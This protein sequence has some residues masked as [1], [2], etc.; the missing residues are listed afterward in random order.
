MFFFLSSV[1]Q[2]KERSKFGTGILNV[3]NKDST[4]SMKI[5]ARAQFLTSSRWI[6][7]NTTSPISV[8]SARRVRLK[9]DGFA[10][11]SRLKYKF[12][13][14]FSDRDISLAPEFT[15]AV[16]RHFFD[17]VLKWNFIGNFTLWLGQAK[18]PG[19]R[20]R[21]IS[22]GDLQQ[23]DRSL[24]NRVF[25]VDRGIGVQL[26]HHFNITE[27]FIVKEMI[28]ISQGEGRGITTGNLGG[29][30]Y[31]SRVEFLPMG[32]FTSEGDYVG[33]D[34]IFE[35]KPKLAFGISYDI[36]TNAVKNRSNLGAYMRNDIGFYKTNISTF[37]LDAM[38][39]YKG[40]S[41]MGEYASRDA[42]DPFAKN[43]DG[44]LTGDIVQVGKGL[45]LQTGYLVSKTLELSG[46]Y[47]LISLDEGITG[48]GTEQQYTFG[49]SKYIIGHKLKVQ[50]DISYLDIE[51]NNDE[52][53]FR[54]QVDI[55]F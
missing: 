25:N 53:M 33:S 46:R 38:F 34:L 42:D 19:N 7:N 17:A 22:S 44:S 50:T 30:Q 43:T 13:F 21:V 35:S 1:A 24:L 16:S 3:I 9:L 52:L 26:R 4:Y 36:N 47:T 11:T 48:K 20:E 8:F 28:A 31:T 54:F 6:D 23:V 14:G 29:Y 32:N 41:F 27:D 15:S 49:I 2:E 39:K 45:N 55:H 18:L 12:E 51:G 37:F 40:F 5:G 10:I